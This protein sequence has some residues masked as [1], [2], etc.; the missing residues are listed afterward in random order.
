MTLPAA[1]H[2]PLRSPVARSAAG[3]PRQPTRRVRSICRPVRFRLPWRT[4]AE[5]RCSVTKQGMIT[6]IVILGLVWGGFLLILLK[7]VRKER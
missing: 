5:S 7:A 6:M 4:L 1:L 2:R 3:P